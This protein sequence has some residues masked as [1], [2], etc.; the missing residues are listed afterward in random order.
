MALLFFRFYEPTNGRPSQCYLFKSCGRKVENATFDCALNKE[1]TIEVHPFI[2]SENECEVH[3]QEVN[4]Q[5]NK[6]T[7]GNQY[8]NNAHVSDFPKNW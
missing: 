1:N 8:H 7:K 3:C 4:K 6:Q 5:T 2:E